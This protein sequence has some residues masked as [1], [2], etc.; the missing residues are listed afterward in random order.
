MEMVLHN[1][2]CELSENEVMDIDAGGWK[3]ALCVFGGVV[4]LAWSIPVGCLNLGAGLAL[5]GASIAAIDAG[6]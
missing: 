3:S 2:F 1:G 4:G 5:A 6:V